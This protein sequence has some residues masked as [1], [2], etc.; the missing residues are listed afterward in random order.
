MET[1]IHLTDDTRFFMS[2]AVALIIAFILCIECAK[3]PE[4]RCEYCDKVYRQEAR[5]NTH[6]AV[7]RGCVVKDTHRPA[8]AT[9][10]S[11]ATSTAPAPDGVIVSATDMSELLR[12]NRE[13]LEMLR[14]QQDTIHLLVS[15]LAGPCVV[16]A[17]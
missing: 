8:T 13:M 12:Q 2:D 16:N 4:Y 10:T 15:Q 5:Y 7:C 11:T 14:K 9:S 1:N 6:V 3:E 17:K